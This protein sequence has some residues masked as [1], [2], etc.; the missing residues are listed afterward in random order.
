MAESTIRA[1]TGTASDDAIAPAGELWGLAVA[2]SLS[3]TA[4]IQVYDNISTSAGVV[5]AQLQTSGVAGTGPST[6]ETFSAMLFPRPIRMTRGI[7]ISASG[8]VTRYWLYLGGAGDKTSI[9]T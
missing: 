4:I 3:T 9:A 8:G 7:S 2:G 5:V 6:F 1:L